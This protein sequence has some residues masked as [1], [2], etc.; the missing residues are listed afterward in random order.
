MQKLDLVGRGRRANVGT[1]RDAIETHIAPRGHP[2]H[3]LHRIRNSGA[4]T[5]CC[6]AGGPLPN[7][8]LGPHIAA[9]A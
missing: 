9:R 2:I 1:S 6:G 8:L 4:L 7:T 5:R 3:G